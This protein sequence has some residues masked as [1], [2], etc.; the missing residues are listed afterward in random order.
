MR[1]R[2]FIG[3]TLAGSG[4]CR[5]YVDET[6]CK[7]DA[8]CNWRSGYTT[9]KGERV[10]PLCVVKNYS[11]NTT[12]GRGSGSE[13]Q[14]AAASASPWIAHVQRFRAANPGMSYKDALKAASATYQKKMKGGYYY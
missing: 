2:Q 8:S 1:A 4:R 10:N 5:E 12:G 6:V 13:A 11:K 3:P 14:K 9:K 7:A